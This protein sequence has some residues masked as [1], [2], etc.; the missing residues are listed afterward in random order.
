MIATRYLI[1][2][3]IITIL[4]LVPTIIHS[5][6]SATVIDGKSVANIATTLKQFNSQPSHRNKT[7]GM[8]IF[9]STDWFERDYQNEHYEKVRLFAA[10]AYDHKRLYHHAELALSYGHSLTSQGVIYLPEYPDLAIHIL[11]KDNPPMLVAYALLYN[12]TLI[13]NPITH[14]LSDS[15]KLLFSA[16]Q[17]MT[18]LYASQTGGFSLDNLGQSNAVSLLI[19]AI[20]SFKTQETNKNNPAGNQKQLSLKPSSS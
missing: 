12:D 6:M 18:L 5:Y 3:I 15:L 10:R 14:Q 17:P 1:P 9:G 19:A 20:H 11:S 4:A 7:W 2:V 13:A 16:R 8:D